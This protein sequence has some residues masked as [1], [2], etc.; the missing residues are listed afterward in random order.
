MVEF[1]TC[2]KVI[3]PI[4]QGGRFDIGMGSSMLGLESGEQSTPFAWG[5][6]TKELSKEPDDLSLTRLGREPNAWALSN[7]IRSFPPHLTNNAF[8]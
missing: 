1:I 8:I 5:L 4:C 2:C 6:A 7:V 3:C